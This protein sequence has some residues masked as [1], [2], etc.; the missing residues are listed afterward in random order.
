MELLRLKV[1]SDE[2]QGK[3]KPKGAKAGKGRC[4][5]RLRMTAWA[6][7]SRQRAY[8][9]LL[10]AYCFP[11]GGEPKGVSIPLWAARRAMG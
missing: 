6:G 9:I 4:F 8:R 2:W 3:A 11:P 10:T 5:A 1:T 7:F